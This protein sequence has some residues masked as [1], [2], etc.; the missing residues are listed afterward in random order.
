VTTR[1]TIQ[2]VIRVNA[3]SVDGT[4]TEG[5]AQTIGLQQAPIMANLPCHDGEH[6]IET[7]RRRDR[8]RLATR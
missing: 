4:L 5:P 3:V 8:A 6:R 2:K 1:D 7:A